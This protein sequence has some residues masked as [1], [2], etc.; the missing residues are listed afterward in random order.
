MGLERAT[1]MESIITKISS[2]LLLLSLRVHPER[3]FASC[4]QWCFVLNI[5]TPGFHQQCKQNARTRASTN[6]SKRDDP[7]EVRF[8]REISLSETRMLDLYPQQD[9]KHHQPF[10]TG[11]QFLLLVPYYQPIEI[12]LTINKRDRK[13]HLEAF[14]SHHIECLLWIVGR[15]EGKLV[16]TGSKTKSNTSKQCP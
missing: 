2:V 6:E 5:V 10:R 4:K 16:I 12:E 11:V 13:M 15:G 9:H 3:Y 7:S 14:S 1:E 8:H